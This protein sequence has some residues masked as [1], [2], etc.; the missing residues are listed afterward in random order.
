MNAGETSNRG[1][2]RGD[3]RV[4]LPMSNQLIIAKAARGQRPNKVAQMKVGGRRSNL[5]YSKARALI[6]IALSTRRR[7]NTAG[8]LPAHS[9]GQF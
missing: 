9:F 3:F 8:R 2:A 5:R 4:A 6:V 7:R 1:V